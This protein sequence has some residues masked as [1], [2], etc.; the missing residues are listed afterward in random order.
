MLA[1]KQLSAGEKLRGLTTLARL[2]LWRFLD[3]HRQLLKRTY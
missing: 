1:S 2:R 3:G